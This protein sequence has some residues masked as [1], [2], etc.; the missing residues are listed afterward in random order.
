MSLF[1]IQ[2]RGELRKLFA[3]KRTY[4]GFGA[5]LIVEI[6]VMIG[7]QMP[8]AQRSFKRMIERA[9]YGFDEY[10]SGLTL[11]FEMLR[12][13]IL[14][15]GA[16]YLALVAGDVVSKEVEEG[17]MRMTL[18]RPISRLRVLM[19]K[20]VSCG[21]YTFALIFFIGITALLAATA[22]RG[23]G[24]LFVFA[25]VER[26]F[27]LYEMWEGLQ[28]YGLALIFL[29]I[30]LFTIT[31]LGFLLSCCNMKPAAATIVTLSILF[32]DMIFRSIP[33]FEDYQTFFITTHMATW[34]NAFKPEI[35]VRQ[36]VQDF[37]F[38]FGVDATMLIAGIA[39]FQGRDFK[40]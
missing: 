25:P 6:L 32:V 15:L 2:L 23:T 31:S 19:L 3:R 40:S 12:W 7:F 37:A 27:A 1:F 17:T 36:L 5:F 13:T 18:C 29:S 24:G 11:A 14:L 34:V 10:F 16:L 21:I 8:P 4:I 28:R 26:I 22:W 20:Y 9:G 39:V 30:T 38:L 33:Y 35:P